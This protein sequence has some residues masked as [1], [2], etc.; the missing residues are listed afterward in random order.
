MKAVDTNDLP[1]N[2]AHRMPLSQEHDSVEGA[3]RSCAV[4]R[5][6][7]TTRIIRVDKTLYGV[8][9]EQQAC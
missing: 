9:V 2:I 4:W 3:L 5:V 6:C 1:T 7:A 8:V